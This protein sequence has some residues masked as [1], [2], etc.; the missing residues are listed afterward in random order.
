MKNYDEGNKRNLSE[1]AEY[2]KLVLWEVFIG[3]GVAY[4][5]RKFFFVSFRSCDN[6]PRIRNGNPDIDT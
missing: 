1:C 5:F 3:L 6:L 4:H 2:W